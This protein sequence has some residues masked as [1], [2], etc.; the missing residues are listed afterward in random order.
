MNNQMPNELATGS[1]P[2][3]LMEVFTDWRDLQ[4]GDVLW[5]GYG[6]MTTGPWTLDALS[7]DGSIL[8]TLPYGAATRRMYFKE[9]EQDIWVDP[10]E[11]DR[12]SRVPS[13]ISGALDQE[14]HGRTLALNIDGGDDCAYE[15]L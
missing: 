5:I 15:T 4:P 2:D 8:W 12:E 13:H 14:S 1:Q 11:L 6:N 9:D 7:K 10:G 3:G